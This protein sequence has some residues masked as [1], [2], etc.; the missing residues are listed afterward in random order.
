MKTI[1]FAK[2]KINKLIGRLLYFFRCE[3]HIQKLIKKQGIEVIYQ[4]KEQE[5]N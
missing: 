1:A 2:V 3:R 4:D 5:K